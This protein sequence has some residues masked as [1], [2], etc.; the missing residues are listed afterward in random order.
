MG[1]AASLLAP[2]AVFHGGGAV[3][4][5]GLSCY[6]YTSGGYVVQGGLSAAGAALAWLARLLRGG[7]AP[8]D[9]AAL[10][11]AAADSPPGARGL[12]C[13]PHLR[14][15]GTPERD[16]AARAAFVGLGEQHGAGDMWRALIEGLACWARLNLEA[17]EAATRIPIT[18]LTLIGGAARGAL[19]P[20]AL[21][22]I[23]G[24]VVAQPEIAEA[25]ARGAALLSGRAIGLTAHPPTSGER[26][27]EPDTGRAVL[28]ERLYREA[29]A[30]LYD[31]LR[32]INHALDALR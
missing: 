2:S 19:L 20:Q 11:R 23:S 30:P 8:E 13:L 32:P 15:S 4:A 10:D 31:A 7:A 9:Y 12:I 17:T 16:S 27:I 5:Q 3:F 28:Y 24:R 1:T 29:Y 26:L 21:A 18:R 6:C 22:D 14:G 25:G